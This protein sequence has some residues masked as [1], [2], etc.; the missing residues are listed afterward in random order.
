MDIDYDPGFL[1]YRVIGGVFD[2]YFFMVSSQGFFFSFL[3]F[4]VMLIK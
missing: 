3:F 2:F 1:R 4:R